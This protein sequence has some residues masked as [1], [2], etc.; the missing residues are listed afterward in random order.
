MRRARVHISDD[1]AFLR[2]QHLESRASRRPPRDAQRLN[3]FPELKAT[4]WLDVL[5]SSMLSR[6]VADVFAAVFT[7]PAFP[8]FVV[9]LGYGRSSFTGSNRSI[10]H[11]RQMSDK[12][13][14]KALYKFMTTP[15]TM[16]AQHRE[17]EP[18]ESK[19]SMVALGLSFTDCDF[20]VAS[21]ESIERLLDHVF[22]HPDRCIEL[23]MLDIRNVMGVEELAVLVRIVHKSKGVYQVEALKLNGIIPG[24]KASASPPAEVLSRFLDI[25]RAVLHVER[26]PA[27]SSSSLATLPVTQDGVQ[28]QS[29][30]PRRISLTKNYLCPGFF[31]AYGSTL[32][33]GCPLEEDVSKYIVIKKANA[34]EK[35][36]GWH[37]LAFGL[38][39]PRPKRSAR[40][41]KLR[42]I[43]R[44]EVSPEAVE[45]F[46]RTLH[47]PAAELVYSPG[48]SSDGTIVPA[49][50]LMI[51]TVE[52]FDTLTK[53]VVRT[54]TLQ[55][56][57][58]LETIC[59]RE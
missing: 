14:C 31:A 17:G 28:Q 25:V 19:P 21:L 37:W 44:L 13:Q 18:S 59:E 12:V 46:V 43:N 15:C 58:E 56:R 40:A 11:W 1:A 32:R 3:A 20:T 50:D 47:N 6:R 5:H 57:S 36:N 35:R 10:A 4:F 30:R 2:R 33:Y 27:L 52:I 23:T 9:D 8:C 55:E 22:A 38:F 53:Q 16:T 39:Y 29:S 34:E 41:F 26:F 42:D 45:T 24:V 54:D 51:C 7:S 48:N 49:T